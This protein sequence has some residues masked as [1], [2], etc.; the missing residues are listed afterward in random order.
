MK[1]EIEKKLKVKI[2]PKEDQSG[3]KTSI[4]GVR[5]KL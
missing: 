5:F 2:D 1:E 3:G 4:F